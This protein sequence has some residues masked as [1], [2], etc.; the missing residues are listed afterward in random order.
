VK[1][2]VAVER[3]LMFS[4]GMRSPSIGGRRGRSEAGPGRDPGPVEGP[5]VKLPALSRSS[6]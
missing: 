4:A 5:R 6:L 1:A 2:L 3:L